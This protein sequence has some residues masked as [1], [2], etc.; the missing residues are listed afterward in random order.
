MLERWK[1]K[2]AKRDWR[3]QW[4]HTCSQCGRM[5]TTSCPSWRLSYVS[6]SP[7]WRLC[8]P[9]P[10][11]LPRWTNTFCLIYQSQSFPLFLAA[12]QIQTQTSRIP[13]T[14]IRDSV[15]CVN[16]CFKAT[17]KIQSTTRNIHPVSP[18]DFR[19]ILGLLVGTTETRRAV[20]GY[21]WNGDQWVPEAKRPQDR[22]KVNKKSESNSNFEKKFKR[23]RS[24]HAD[25]VTI[26]IAVLQIVL[27]SCILG[28]YS[29]LT[30]HQ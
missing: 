21:I 6:P 26:Y 5:W 29:I 24:R 15:W 13:W 28:L 11:T 25:V 9:T 8:P 2:K 23:N 3:L 14:K 12:L 20:H 16:G 17:S 27:I 19:P 18:S 10:S 7:S 4:P 1:K 22:E 30:W